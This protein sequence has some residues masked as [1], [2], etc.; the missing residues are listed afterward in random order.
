MLNA[1]ARA[2]QDVCMGFLSV[3]RMGSSSLVSWLWPLN[4]SYLE[5]DPKADAFPSFDVEVC[6]PGISLLDEKGAG[7]RVKI[8]TLS[9]VF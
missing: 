2:Y 4:P 8:L 7:L 9:A 1:V 5:V 3:V 6:I